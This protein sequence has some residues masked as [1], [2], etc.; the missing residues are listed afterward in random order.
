MRATRRQPRSGHAL[1]RRHMA[2]PGNAVNVGS[3]ELAN[4]VM[5]ASGTAGYGTELGRLPRPVG[6]RC[7]RGQVA[8]GLRVGRQP[9]AAAAPDAEGD[10][11]RR[12]P[13][14]TWRAVL[15]GPRASRPARNRCHR[16]GVDLGALG[17]RLRPSRGSA[18]RS[19][20]G[21]RR[22][23]GQPVVPQSRGPRC[24]LRPRPRAVG[25]GRRRDRRVR[26]AALGEVERQHRPHR[27]GRR[28]RRCCRRRGG[29]LHQHPAR[30]GLRPRARDS[31]HSV[32]A[33]AGCPARRSI[34]S[35]C[36]PCTT[37]TRPTPTCR[38]SASAAWRRAG[39]PPS[40]CSPGPSPCRSARRRS[41]TREP[42]LGCSPSCAIHPPRRAFG[43]RDLHGYTSATD[44]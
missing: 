44:S 21:G 25:P 23:R 4:P 6:A 19:T 28:R 35:P 18:R 11:Q 22:R 39:T 20:A 29:D 15:A 31:R 16:R 27:R 14:G 17:R 33:A 1:R 13:A 36:A 43:Y 38:S 24:H 42:R 9:G 3:V 37:S 2:W 12:R 7:R 32:P 41:P 10:A 5:T 8:R 30:P 40:C 34:P 26:S